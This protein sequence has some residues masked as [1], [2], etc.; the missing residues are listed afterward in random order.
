MLTNLLKSIVPGCEKLHSQALH[1]LAIFYRNQGRH[2]L[3]ED[4][5]GAA[6]QLMKMTMEAE[7]KRPPPGEK[8]A[9]KDSGK[10]GEA[11]LQSN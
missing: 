6:Q 11:A 8:P 1:Q 7:R 4:R 2:D 9:T 5:L 3:A 10:N